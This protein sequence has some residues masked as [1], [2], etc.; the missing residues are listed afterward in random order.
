V[1]DSRGRAGRSCDRPSH[2]LGEM[3]QARVSLS[4]AYA[5]ATRRGARDGEPPLPGS[6]GID[7]GAPISLTDARGADK[8]QNEPHL[9]RANQ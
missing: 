4:N 1:T 9:L 6:W 8:A 7:S 2:A 5:L 3:T